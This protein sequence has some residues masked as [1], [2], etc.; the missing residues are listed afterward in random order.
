M[1][2]KCRLCRIAVGRVLFGARERGDNVNFY[3]RFINRVSEVKTVEQ[4]NRVLSDMQED[5]TERVR[6]EPG[7]RN[8]LSEQYQQLKDICWRAV[9]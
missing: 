3:D 2:R 1:C 4:R 5:F 6:N 7:N 8:T 9:A